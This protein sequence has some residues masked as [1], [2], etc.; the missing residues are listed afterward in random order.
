MDF[1]YSPENKGICYLYTSQSECFLHCVDASNHQTISRMF[2][3]ADNYRSALNDVIFLCK[4]YGVTELE[5]KILSRREMNFRNNQHFGVEQRFDPDTA[6]NMLSNNG[7]VIRKIENKNESFPS[8]IAYRKIVKNM[9]EIW[10]FEEIEI[11]ENFS[12]M[13]LLFPTEIDE[14]SNDPIE[15]GDFCVVDQRQIWT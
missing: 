1:Y 7:I 2:L 8:K 14:P 6:I 10:K 15:G 4:E 9:W 13:G 11:F 5:V 3:F 12:F